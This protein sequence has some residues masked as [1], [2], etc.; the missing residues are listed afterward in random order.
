[1]IMQC[2]KNHLFLV[3]NYKTSTANQNPLDFKE[4]KHLKWQTTTAANTQNVIITIYI[5]SYF[6]F[7]I[8]ILRVNE[9]L[10]L[11]SGRESWRKSTLLLCS[12][13]AE[14]LRKHVG[15]FRV[16]WDLECHPHEECKINR[17]PTEE[18]PLGWMYRA[19]SG[20]HDCIRQCNYNGLS[21]SP[22]K[23]HWNMGSF[24]KWELAS[25]TLTSLPNNTGS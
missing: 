12:T 16:C 15:A 21:V 11:A 9:P 19:T 8:T 20:G 18:L 10:G 22:E 13:S 5:Y 17:F 2:H 25:L 23:G 14:Y 3:I 4:L 1:M 7:I 6:F 24:Q